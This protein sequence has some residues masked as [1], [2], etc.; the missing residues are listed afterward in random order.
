M[1]DIVQ[2]LE[3]EFTPE[4]NLGRLHRACPNQHPQRYAALDTTHALTD[5]T[6]VETAVLAYRELDFCGFIG[7]IYYNEPL[8]DME[9]MFRSM[10]AISARVSYA[11]FMLWTNGNL[12]PEDCRRFARFEQIFVSQYSPD[13]LT[14]Q[15][16]WL[17]R[18]APWAKVLY[19]RQLDDRLRR[20]APND[21]ALP[22]HRPFV[23]FIIDYHGNAHLCCYDWRGEVPLGNIFNEPLRRIVCRW[24]HTIKD[25]VGERM[26]EAAPKACRECGHRGLGYQPH[27][28]GII[29]RAERWRQ[30]LVAS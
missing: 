1:L 26:T 20:V 4:C 22:C 9:R 7:W 2:I 21:P 12:I 23:E 27:D 29:A 3:F 18:Y 25:I 13:P 28:F 17:R 15:I 19:D 5:E 6:I 16:E 30:T 24:R 10:D 14:Q 8:T 11:R